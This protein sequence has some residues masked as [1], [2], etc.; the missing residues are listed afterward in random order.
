MRAMAAWTLI[1]AL[2]WPAAGQEPR[3][4]VRVQIPEAVVFPVTDLRAKAAAR[5]SLLTFDHALLAP[6]SRLRISV[7]AEGLDLGTGAPAR[8]SYAARARGGTPFSGA[9]RDVEFTPVFESDPLALSGSVEVAW[10]LE[11]LGGSVRAGERGVTL[12]W[13]VESLPGATG[14]PG[15]SP[16]RRER[17][18]AGSGLDR[19][20][21][22]T[23]RPPVGQPVERE[24][25][26]ERRRGR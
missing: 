7:R 6:G 12:R 15:A 24:L 17:R 5:P 13:K 26:V 14:T 9:L 10:T 23:A 8:I 20:V 16:F 1:A 21:D 22:E 3:Q 19:P 25:R 2:A 4:Q 18:R 11:P